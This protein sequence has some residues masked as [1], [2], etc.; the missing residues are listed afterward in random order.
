MSR[1]SAGLICVT[2]MTFL[3]FYFRPIWHTDVWGHLAY[4]RLIWES[5]SLP[6]TEP[7]LPLS[8]GVRF[9]DTAWLSQVIGFGAIRTWGVSGLQG[10][11]ALCISMCVGLLAWRG[12]Q[13]STN[14]W[15]G[16]LSVVTFLSVGWTPLIVIRPQLAGVVCFVALLSILT[17]PHRRPIE[18]LVVPG[19][20][21]AWANFHGSFVIGLAFLGC[22]TIGRAADVMRRTRSLSSIVRDTQFRRNG[23]LLAFAAA[24]V[25]LNPYGGELYTET[26]RIASNENLQELTEWSPLSVRETQGKIF[27]VVSVGLAMLYRYSPRRVQAW[28]IITL[29]SFG[30]AALSSNRM[31]IWWAP[32]AAIIVAVHGYAVWRIARHLPLVATPKPSAGKW[33]VVAV[34]LICICFA[35]ILLGVTMLQAKGVDMKWAVTRETPLAA[36]EYLKRNPPQGLVFNVF[37]WGDFLIWNGPPGMKVFVNS[38]AHLVPRDVWQSYLRIIEQRS[39]WE[40]ELQ[41]YKINTIVLDQMY[42]APLIEFFKGSPHWKVGFEQDGQTVFIRQRPI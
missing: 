5:Q 36:A 2:G 26:I 15:F 13:K 18:W 16:L 39:G 8:K 10:L 25:L 14:A 7:F 33:T 29:L 28:E 38:H 32:I 1:S 35:A 34:G 19:L 22:F 37:E 24:A 6:M 9:V 4:G 42:R 41:R 21:V 30:W 17:S 40:Q 12:Y 3:F 23:L 20:F 27:A 11:Y 31:L